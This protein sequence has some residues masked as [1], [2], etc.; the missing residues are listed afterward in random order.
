MEEIKSEVYK[1]CLHKPTINQ[2]LNVKS[3]VMESKIKPLVE[4]ESVPE[5]SNKQKQ[6]QFQNFMERM[7]ESN[8]RSNIKMSNLRE[9]KE[10]REKEELLKFERIRNKATKKAPIEDP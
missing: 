2:N 6:S 5:Q 10:Q 8:L 9:M 3:R 7:Q 4:P 1:E